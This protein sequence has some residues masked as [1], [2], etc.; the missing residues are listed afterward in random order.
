MN[1]VEVIFDLLDEEQKPSVFVF[2]VTKETKTDY[3]AKRKSED[4]P[5]RRF[6][7]EGLDKIIRQK[8]LY[9]VYRYLTEETPEQINTSEKMK[10]VGKLMMSEIG[11]DI[12]SYNHQ[13]TKLSNHF[14]NFITH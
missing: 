9:Y 7:K 2:V 5:S 10:D 11:Y 12:Q 8:P 4:R 13:L 1:A 14:V 6:C 3:L